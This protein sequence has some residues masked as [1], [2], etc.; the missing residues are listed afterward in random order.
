MTRVRAGDQ[1]VCERECRG[2][3]GVDWFVSHSFIAG[4]LVLYLHIPVRPP[5]FAVIMC[6]S[7]QQYGKGGTWKHGIRELS[8][9]EV[10]AGG[11]LK[12]FPQ[13]SRKKRVAAIDSLHTRMQ[14]HTASP[15]THATSHSPSGA[16]RYNL[17]FR[18]LDRPVEV[19]KRKY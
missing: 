6:G 11:E 5:S 2:A 17:T 14:T 1:S 3:C 13:L 18:S 16:P 12:G 7:M 15:N 8:K 9:Q 10:A 19:G 4:R